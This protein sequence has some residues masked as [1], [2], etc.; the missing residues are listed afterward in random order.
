MAGSSAARAGIEGGAPARSQ[1]ASRELIGR[2][3]GAS[4]AGKQNYLTGVP[5]SAAP[6]QPASPMAQAEELTARLEPAD[7]EDMAN[8]GHTTNTYERP[9][10]EEVGRTHGGDAVP[11]RTT[12]DGPPPGAHVVRG[13]NPAT[14][15]PKATWAQ[16]KGTPDRFS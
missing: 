6:A 11:R 12:A 16:P 15:M 7:A 2:E 8:H 14:L 3:F 4:G 1:P 13:V 9:R 10:P 5:W